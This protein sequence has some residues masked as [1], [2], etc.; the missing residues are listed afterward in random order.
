VPCQNSRVSAD[1]AF[2]ARQATLRYSL[3]RPV[4]V[5]NLAAGLTWDF[6]V[7]MISARV[8]DAGLPAAGDRSFLARV[9]GTVLLVQGRGDTRAP[10]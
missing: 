4:L 7:A 3:I 5:E 6:D 2:R 9:A 8:R 10:A 1:L